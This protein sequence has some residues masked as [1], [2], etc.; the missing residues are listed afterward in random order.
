M[1]DFLTDVSWI[2]TSIGAWAL[3]RIG[4]TV[5]LWTAAALLAEGLLRAAET[6]IRPEGATPSA[7]LFCSRYPVPSCSVRSLR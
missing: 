7:E 6:Q 2:L 4:L 5:L 3:P 1:I